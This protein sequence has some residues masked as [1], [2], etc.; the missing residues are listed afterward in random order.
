MQEKTK[1][2]IVKRKSA[3]REW[4]EF[5]L[6]VFVLAFFIRTFI[7]QAFRIP[8]GSM[9]DTLLVG[10][11]LL[12]NKI[13]YGPRIPFTHIRLPGIRDP[14]PG[15][16]IIFEYPIDPSKDFI[17][18]VIAVEGQTVEIRDKDVYV[19]GVKVP[20]PPKGKYID[21]GRVLPKFLS[22]RDNFGP[23]TVPKDMIFVMGD[24]RDNSRDSRYWGW[25]P[26]GNVKGKA[27]FIYWSWNNDNDVPV[28]DLIHKIRWSRIGDI[29]R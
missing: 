23:V 12:A 8:S 14:K 3:F 10:D 11:F 15:D 2:K 25:V 26:K 20:L 18:R 9:E 27:M 4:V 6:T 17:K 5:I 19:D 16:V 7:V 24:N 1:E 13:V 29:I 28:W 22:P 21:N